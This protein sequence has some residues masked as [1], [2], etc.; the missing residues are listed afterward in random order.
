MAATISVVITCHNYGRYLR[1][2]LESVL[3][4][5]R[6]A[7]EI[8]VVDD[9]STDD[10]PAVAA[11]YAGRGIRYER[12]EFRSATSSY[13]HGIATTTGDLIAFVD[14]DN[15]LTPRFLDTLA[16]ALEVDAGLGFAYS[17]RYW[18]GEA[19]IA[20]WQDVGAMPGA[21]FP[22]FPPDLAMLVHQ[23]FI[24]TMSLVRRAAVAQVGGFR[25]M[26]IL[27]DYQ[28]WLAI[29]ECGWRPC[30]VPVPLYHYRVHT[31]N[32]IVATRPQ[33]R[34][35]YL[36]IRREHFSRPFWA[37]YTHPD[38]GLE[39][40]VTVGPSLPGG[41]PIQVILSPVVR[42][43]AYPK[44]VWLRVAVPDGLEFLDAVPDREKSWLDPFPSGVA[45]RFPYP[46]PDGVASAI[47][48]QAHLRLVA[49]APLTDAA[50]AVTLEWDDLF[51]HKHEHCER[52]PVPTATV[53]PPAQQA[54]RPGQFQVIRGHFGGGEPITAW[55]A[56]PAG[57]PR[58][59]APLPVTAADTT[60]TVVIDLRY[61]PRDF[62]AIVVQ[63]A[64][65]RNQVVLYPPGPPGATARRLAGQVLGRS[66]AKKLRAE[67]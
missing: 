18:T 27:W 13:N 22:S 12:V 6:P 35:C 45:I 67:D 4:Q 10:T 24:D 30:Y 23:N 20:A 37:D 63:G 52:V 58:A 56:L 64:T 11:H 34:G 39:G 49:R 40:S 54:L 44:F 62:T 42:G 9:A 5:Q 25:E 21:V 8:V 48:P 53:T 7:D 33:H 41:T 1:E 46:V 51:D 14:A 26:P 61:A 16:G 50:L 65:W 38:L 55:A 3:A 66:R 60:G 32:M 59:S 19:T 2:C 36:T 31:G 43:S 29:L 47:P 57:A 15:A 28:L 17:D